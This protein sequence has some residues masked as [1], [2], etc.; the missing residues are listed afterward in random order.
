MDTSFNMHA[1][2]ESVL[3]ANAFTQ[4]ESKDDLAIAGSISGMHAY[5]KPNFGTEHWPFLTRSESKNALGRR[6]SLRASP[7]SVSHMVISTTCDFSADGIEP[8]GWLPM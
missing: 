1:C 3:G 4:G 7:E 5:R 6:T 2:V 8:K